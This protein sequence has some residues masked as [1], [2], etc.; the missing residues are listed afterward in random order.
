MTASRN[1]I[2]A[3]GLMLLTLAAG[4]SVLGASSI[5]CGGSSCEANC[6][7]DTGG[8]QLAK[9]L[10]IPRATAAA[11]R[12]ATPAAA[13]L[14]T[15]A[16]TRVPATSSQTT[17]ADD[18]PLLG[19]CEPYFKDL[20]ETCRG[21]PWKAEASALILHRSTPGTRAVLFDPTTG[22][23]LFDASRTGISLSRP[24]RGFPSPPWTARAGDSS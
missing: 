1:T 11:V 19:A 10:A 24:A 2:L 15:P 4:K 8:V 9:P 6:G 16:E 12:D 21:L 5:G 20:C 17:W 13:P 23:D 18:I 14:A 3:L 22:A 7:T